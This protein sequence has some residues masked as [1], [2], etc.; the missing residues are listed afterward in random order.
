MQI[1]MH[2][3]VFLSYENLSDE[4][5]TKHMSLYNYSKIQVIRQLLSSL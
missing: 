3:S 2:S 4:L 1:S 5:M